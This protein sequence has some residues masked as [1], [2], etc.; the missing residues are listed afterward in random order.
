[1]LRR[2][3]WLALLLAPLAAATPAT[4]PYSFEASF[5]EDAWVGRLVTLRVAIVAERALDAPVRLE[6]PAW[7]DVEDPE[8]HARVAEGERAEHAWRVRATEAGFWRA[9]L[10]VDA[11]RAQAYADPVDPARAWQPLGG[12]CCLHVWSFKER[13]MAAAEPGRAVPGESAVGF[14]TSLRAL[15]ASRAELAVL[16][17]PQDARFA[18]EEIVFQIPTGVEL[19]RAPADRP[20]TFAHAFPLANGERA[21]LT[22]AA[23]VWITFEAGEHAGDEVATALPIACA[24]IEVERAGDDVREVSRAGCE[25]SAARP[26][27]IPAPSALVALAMAMTIA[28]DG[29]SPERA[30]PAARAKR[31]SSLRGR[32]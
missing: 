21:M 13:A 22:P 2:A 31:S 11:A 24:N 15:D 25:A 12:G 6:A 10:A 7:V 9:S 1:M 27:A 4:E 29:R 3:A 18:H 28:R 23:S 30:R 17:S 32:A 19:A 26:R 14:H 5:D 8:W 16:V 20:R